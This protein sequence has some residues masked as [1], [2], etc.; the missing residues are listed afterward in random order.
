M[1]SKERVRAAI[2]HRQPDR[3]P[4]DIECLDDVWESLMQHFGCSAQDDVLDKLEIDIRCVDYENAYV[5]PELKRQLLDNGEIVADCYWGWKWRAYP[6]YKGKNL[7]FVAFDPPLDDAKTVDDV[8][9]HRWP[10]PDWFDYDAIRQE[11]RKYDDKAVI[12]G[13]AGVFQWG[14]F[15]RNQEKLFAEMAMNPDIPRAIFDK[16]VEFELEFYD[17]VLTVADGAIDILKVADDFGTQKN[18]FFSPGMWRDFF[19]ENLRKLTDLAHRHGAY[20]M[21][22]SCGAIRSLIP[23]L[24]ACGVDILDP[25]QKLPGLEP[26]GLKREFG[27]RLTFHGG[28]DT[29]HL[30]PY[31]T[32]E[33]VAAETRHFVEVLNRD[34]GYI[35]AATVPLQADVP[36]ENVLA[37]YATRD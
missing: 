20:F 25:I 2:E 17:R 29:Q 23:E 21:I 3:V 9:A 31:G 6:N 11:C 24:V 18:A 36:I 15:A 10:D 1:T 8:L 33:A 28:I 13:N 34:G 32:P 5:G 26:E 14:T 12:F 19:A 37:M 4:V 27:D 35:L 7:V 30:L 22:H 16:C